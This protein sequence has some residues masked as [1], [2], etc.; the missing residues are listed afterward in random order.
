MC[1]GA[2]S[3][4]FA[5]ASAKPPGPGSGIRVLGILGHISGPI[6]AHPDACGWARYPPFFLVVM[7]PWRLP[8]HYIV[9]VG[10]VSNGLR[11]SSSGLPCNRFGPQR[12]LL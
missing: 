9:R 1:V 8:V 11:C 6:M 2:E 10:G 4:A 12:T 7:F 3:H 5:G